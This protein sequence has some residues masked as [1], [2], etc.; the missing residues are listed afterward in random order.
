[1]GNPRAPLRFPH[2]FEQF[3]VGFANVLPE[4]VSASTFFSFQIDSILLIVIAHEDEMRIIAG[5]NFSNTAL[6]C[7]LATVWLTGRH[8]WLA[9]IVGV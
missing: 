2:A 9:G 1:M 4:S 8:A 3:V 6:M 7:P 5:C